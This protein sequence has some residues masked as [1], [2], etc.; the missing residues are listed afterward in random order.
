MKHKYSVTY[1]QCIHDSN[2][3]LSVTDMGMCRA[4][5]GNMESLVGRREVRSVM[6]RIRELT[7]P[8]SNGSSR[9]TRDLKI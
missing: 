8:V 7:L 6:A 5:T 9:D 1:I 4:W 2:S 3:P